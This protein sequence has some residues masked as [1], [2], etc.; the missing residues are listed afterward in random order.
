MTQKT[1]ELTAK[2]LALASHEQPCRVCFKGHMPAALSC[3]T[4]N[5]RSVVFPFRDAVTVECPCKTATPEDKCAYC[6][7]AFEMHSKPHASG[8]EG[9]MH[10][11]TCNGTDHVLRESHA[12]I[13]WLLLAALP[14]LDLDFEI[15]GGK[16]EDREVALFKGTYERMDAFCK[17]SVDHDGTAD[18]MLAALVDALTEAQVQ[19]NADG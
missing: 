18:S 6:Y 7:D 3:D 1:D 8:T 15:K 4:C 13:G 16:Q 19:E 5:G 10:C 17:W 2:L 9:V 11:E 12:E 14:L